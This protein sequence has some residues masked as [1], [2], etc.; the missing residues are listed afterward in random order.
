M[1][2]GAVRRRVGDDMTKFKRDDMGVRGGG[3]G[4]EGGIGMVVGGDMRN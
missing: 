4:E 1:G 3:R 2:M